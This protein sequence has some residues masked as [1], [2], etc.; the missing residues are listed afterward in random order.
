[1]QTTVTVYL[2]FNLSITTTANQL[3]AGEMPDAQGMVK[4]ICKVASTPSSANASAGKAQKNVASTLSFF[5]SADAKTL[6]SVKF[7]GA[8]TASRII[9]ARGASGF[10]NLN[11]LLAVPRTNFVPARADA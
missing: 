2:N 6:Q 10:S 4:L 5:N 3:V 8:T 11:A 7:I 9:E 1:M